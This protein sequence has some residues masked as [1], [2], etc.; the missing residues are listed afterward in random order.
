[1]SEDIPEDA[2]FPLSAINHYSFCPRRC[3]LVHSECIWSENFFTASGKVLHTSVDVGGSQARKETRSVRSLRLYSKELGVSG[4]A[5]VV[6]FHRDDLMGIP[7]QGWAGRWRPCPVEYKRGSAKNEIPYER[8]LCAQAIC[9][10][11]IFHIKI[12]EGELFLGVTKHRRTVLFN[13]KLRCD[14]KNVCTAIRDLLTSG[15]IPPA[16]MSIHCKSCSLL[17]DC[18]PKLSFR[19][20]RAWLDHIMDEAE[21]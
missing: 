20:A 4:I 5:D 1:M 15:L 8:Q 11:E 21:K 13:D 7:V 12:F 19:S 16:Q 17:N 2:F 6:E 14:T 9:L 3:A 10:E 18:I